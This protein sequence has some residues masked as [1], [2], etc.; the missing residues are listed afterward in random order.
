MEID[1]EFL[2]MAIIEVYKKSLS[3]KDEALRK[4]TKR[5]FLEAR[6]T[7]KHKTSI[8]TEMRRLDDMFKE[9]EKNN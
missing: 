7:A 3:E 8:L 4:K 6:L 1:R 2:G 5:I 9:E